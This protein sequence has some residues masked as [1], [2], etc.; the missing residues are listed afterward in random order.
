MNNSCL[1]A[2]MLD[3]WIRSLVDA[4]FIPYIIVN[5]ITNNTERPVEVP[6]SYVDDKGTIVLNVSTTA[7]SVFDIDFKRGIAYC[8]ARFKGI[9]TSMVIPIEKITMVQSKC[10]TVALPLSPELEI[11]QNIDHDEPIMVKETSDTIND[12]SNNKKPFLTL[13]K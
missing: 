7:V 3:A 8:T 13:V 11:I 12:K 5:T 9:P 6:Q 4:G 10:G 1:N 2:Y